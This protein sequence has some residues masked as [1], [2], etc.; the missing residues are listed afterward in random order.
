MVKISVFHS[1]DILD[2]PFEDEEEM[3]AQRQDNIANKN[4][5]QII[6]G[7]FCMAPFYNNQLDIQHNHTGNIIN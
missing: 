6:Q 5:T 2:E 1:Q 3:D 4:K 7:L